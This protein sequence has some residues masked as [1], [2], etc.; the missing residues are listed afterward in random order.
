MQITPKHCIVMAVL[1]T[2]KWRAV[3]AVQVQ[4]MQQQRSVTVQ[5]RHVDGSQRSKTVG[6]GNLAHWDQCCVR[7]AMFFHFSSRTANA[8]HTREARGDQRTRLKD[9]LALLR[10]LLNF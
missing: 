6:G 2:E 10:D 5:R 7:K 9:D 1:V 8:M 3:A 4:C